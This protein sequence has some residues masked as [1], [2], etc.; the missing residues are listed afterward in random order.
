ML[1]LLDLILAWFSGKVQDNDGRPPMFGPLARAILYLTGLGLVVAGAFAEIIMAEMFAHPGG[2][3]AEKLMGPVFGVA[4]L[5]LILGS[6]GMLW[7]VWKLT[8]PRAA[9]P[10]KKV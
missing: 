1:G 4:G 8:S 6:V 3:G 2:I 7:A 9:G 10:D 5:T